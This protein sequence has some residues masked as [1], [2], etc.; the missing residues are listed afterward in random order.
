[1]A[2]RRSNGKGRKPKKVEPAQLSMLFV[3]PTIAGSGSE[4]FYVDLSQSASLLNRRFYRQGINWAVG[5][6]KI[7][8]PIAAGSVIVQK[9]PSTWAMSNAWMKG[10]KAW[11]RMNNEALE[12]NE[13]VR[14]R[15]LDFKIFAD[16]QHHL[17]GFG[18]N[19]IPNTYNQPPG[20]VLSAVQATAGEWEASSFRI[21][22]TTIL[23]NTRDREIIAVGASYPGN[24]ASG[25]NAVSLIEGYAASRAL[26]DIED[27]NV[28]DDMS[29]ADGVAPENW[30]TAV[31]N[32]GTEQ[33][34]EVLTDMRTE[35]N[36][37]PYPFEN[38]ANPAGGVFAD[39]MYP[40][41]ANQLDGLQYHDSELITGTTIGGTTHLDG[42]LFPCGLI[43]F[44]FSNAGATANALIQIN[45]VPGNHRG[46]LCEPMT[47]M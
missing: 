7:L 43:K 25:K 1:M 2:Y 8:S 36:I 46:Y 28:P 12:E 16:A 14:P 5:S 21:P 23:A 40:G 27:P 6:I 10:F 39:T 33:S 24:G 11:Q 20:G 30:I 29:D 18:A 32:E 47:E 19:L 31:F 4:E 17:D 15:F 13:S 45:L 44:A 22:D 42:G 3:T 9:L 41:G 26:P 34:D 35:N 37:A 38:G